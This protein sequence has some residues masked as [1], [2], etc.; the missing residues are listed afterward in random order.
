MFFVSNAGRSGTL[1]ISA[2]LMC[3]YVL[4]EILEAMDVAGLS[5]ETEVDVQ[6]PSED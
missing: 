4:E 1:V 6:T 5:G 2:P 3:L